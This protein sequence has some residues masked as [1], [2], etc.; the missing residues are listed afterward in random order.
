MEHAS[1]EQN[2]DGESTTRQ[3]HNPTIGRPHLV[4]T[5]PITPSFAR[6]QLGAMGELCALRQDLTV[7]AWPPSS[8]VGAGQSGSGFSR[9]INRSGSLGSKWKVAGEGDVAGL[10]ALKAAILCRTSSWLGFW[11]EAVVVALGTIG[12]TVTASIALRLAEFL[13]RRDRAR[14]KSLIALFEI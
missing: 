4:T 10:R 13:L 7:T 11:A 6:N 1:R 14:T 8:L 3:S 2:E 9:V 12:V 5:L